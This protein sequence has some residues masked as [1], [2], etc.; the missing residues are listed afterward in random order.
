[1]KTENVPLYKGLNESRTQGNWATI[2][3]GAKSSLRI[4]A[5]DHVQK[6][7]VLDC[8]SFASGIKEEEAKANTEYTALAVNHLAELAQ[9]L[10]K[11]TILNEAHYKDIAGLI[12]NAKEA[13]NRIS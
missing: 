1:M 3:S 4:Y 13:L 12:R 6:T 7:H 11:F 8:Y 5:T 10:E 9:A 2:E